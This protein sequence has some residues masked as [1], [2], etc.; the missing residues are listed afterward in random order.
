MVQPEAAGTQIDEPPDW[1][2]QAEDIVCPLCG[3][4]LRGLTQ[5]RCPE[6]G[7]TF[8]WHKVL[9]PAQRL[10]PY[11]FEHHPKQNLWSF[12][13]T[14]LGGLRP[15]QFWTSLHPAQPSRPLR[16]VLFWLACT[17][18]V[19]LPTGYLFSIVCFEHYTYS[20][21]Q[22]QSTLGYWGRNTTQQQTIVQNFGSV[23]A[24][25]DEYYPLPPSPA[26]FQNA[27]RYRPET[28][29]LGSWA[30]GYMCWPWV[31]LAALMLFQI[32]MRRARIRISHLMRC[33]IYSADVTPVIVASVLV[34]IA[35]LLRDRGL[36]YHL[37]LRLPTLAILILWA[38]PTWRLIVACRRYLRIPMATMTVLLTQIIY[39]LLVAKVALDL[40][41]LD[42]LHELFEIWR[43]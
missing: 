41:R 21:Q 11:L 35:V 22:R 19:L 25:L 1:S 34:A 37:A 29:T 18:M 4:N 2:H 17:L 13:Q 15:G 32:T 20:L 24:A 10:H 42:Y 8:E 7:L 43:A 23:T 12:A 31:T 27:L 28:Q 30:L 6:C 33:T 39:F 3:Y 38:A 5:G 16:L 36:A 40:F 14:L 26:F 9:D